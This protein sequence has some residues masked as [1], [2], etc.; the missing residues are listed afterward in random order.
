MTKDEAALILN[1]KLGRR[2]RPDAA[3]TARREEARRVLGLPPKKSTKTATTTSPNVS[4][5]TEEVT[6]ELVSDTPH[7]SDDSTNEF[8]SQDTMSES[9]DSETNQEAVVSSPN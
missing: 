1:T 3:T 4:T 5:A 9:D 8:S 7:E 6:R 2:G